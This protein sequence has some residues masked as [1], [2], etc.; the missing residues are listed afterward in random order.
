MR[1]L[2]DTQVVYLA[3]SVPLADGA[4]SVKARKVLEDP[5]TERLISTA[6]IMEIAIKSSGGRIVMSENQVAE[7][8]RDLVLSALPFR[9]EHAYKLFSLPAHH[10]D[11]FDRMIIATALVENIPIVGSDRKFS[12]YS[13]VKLIW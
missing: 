2:L 4:L 5:G 8:M 3:A 7:A 11:P 12:D 9:S 10:R 1:V 6:S 13:G